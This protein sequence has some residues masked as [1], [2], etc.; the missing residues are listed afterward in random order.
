MVDVCSRECRIKGCGKGPSFGVAGTRTVEYCAQ[1]APDGMVIVCSTKQRG[2]EGCGKWSSSGVAGSSL[3]DYVMGSKKCRTQGCVMRPSFGVAGTRTAEYCAQHAPNGMV[4]V[5]G[6]EKCRIEGCSN[7]LSFGVTDTRKTAYCIQHTRPRYRF[8]GH[9]RQEIGPHHS[10]KKNI[11]GASGAKRKT[12]PAIFAHASPPSDMSGGSR[13][14][15]QHL[16]ITSTVSERV[17]LRESA[18]GAVTIPKIDP[19][20]SPIKRDSSVKTEVHLSL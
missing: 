17:A 15:V 20:K 19:Q 12:V 6:R 1:H 16:D 4:N 18:A 7:Q 2:T 13:K 11:G 9:S 8:E 5:N 14:R 3:T 10:D